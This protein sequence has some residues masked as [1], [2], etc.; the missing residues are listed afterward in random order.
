MRILFITDKFIPERGG[1]QIIFGNLY[2]HLR[3]H[4]V[5]VVTREC[6]GAEQSDAEYPGRVFRVPYS[7]VPKLRS[8]LLWM[9]LRRRASQLLQSERFDQVHLGQP[10]EVAPWGVPL[11]RKAGLPA[12]IHTFA[13]DVTSFLGHPV[14]LRMMTSA[15]RQATHVTTISLH[16]REYLLKL[17]VP[18]DRI[19]LLYPG[20]DLDRWH[21]TGREVEIRQ[22]F[23]L[24]GKRVILTVARLIPRKGQDTVLKALPETLARVPDAVY[25]LVGG[26]P[27][28]AR[29]RALAQ[30][31]GVAEHVRWAGSIPNHETVDYYHAADV[32][33]MP[34]RRM[35]NGD[36]EGFGLVFLEANVCGLPVIG[37]RSGGAVDAIDHGETGYLVDPEST[38]DVAGRIITLL[39]DPELAARMGAA[40]RQ[41]VIERFTW[42]R[43]AEVLAGAMERASAAATARLPRGSR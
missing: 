27:E 25:L 17:G 11:A 43:S 6:P 29:L 8:P 33:A 30:S 42:D 40:G 18:D 12:V 5:T 21:P 35:P 34:N 3:G 9:S 41:R 20:V 24:G 13:E 7:Q 22:R 37:G 19:S 38:A 26:G 16:T 15:L 1:S 14:Y 36:I 23:G 32:F 39:E 28:E 10:V 4:E 2:S 31:L